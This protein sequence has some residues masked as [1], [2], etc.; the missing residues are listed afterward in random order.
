MSSRGKT[1]IIC[2]VLAPPS[3]AG[4]HVLAIAMR[5]AAV[6]FALRDIDFTIGDMAT[7]M[8]CRGSG[9]MR[10]V[11]AERMQSTRAEN[12]GEW[13]ANRWVSLHEACP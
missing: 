11:Y 1:T 12:C 2:C 13:P 3:L 6:G 9:S 5:Q 8:L 4:M 10:R 7:T